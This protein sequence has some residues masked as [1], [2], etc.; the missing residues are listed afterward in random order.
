[1]VQQYNTAVFRICQ[2][3]KKTSKRLSFFVYG[4]IYLPTL[5]TSRLC[6]PPVARTVKR[7]AVR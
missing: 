1:M 2:Q 4:R 7:I 3:I 5:S 6:N